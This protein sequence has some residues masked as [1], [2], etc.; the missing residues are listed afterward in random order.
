MIFV[1]PTTSSIWDS[2]PVLSQGKMA[3]FYVIGNSK[4]ARQT[5]KSFKNAAHLWKHVKTIDDNI[6]GYGQIKAML[7]ALDGSEKRALEITKKSE[8]SSFILGGFLLGGAAGAIG[9][10]I[11][12]D[13]VLTAS[14]HKSIGVIDH[15]LHFEKKTMSQ[16]IDVILDL[17]LAALEH[18]AVIPFKSLGNVIKVTKRLIMFPI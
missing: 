18:N 3:F 11:A 2:M 5:W 16:H 10:S 17:T 15:A 6:P 7:I 12:S 8:K 14:I 13:G 4:Q 1:E 9:G